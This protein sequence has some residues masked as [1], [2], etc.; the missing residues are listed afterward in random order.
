MPR[1]RR[2]M[3]TLLRR[4]SRYPCLHRRLLRSLRGRAAPRVPSVL[5]SGAPRPAALGLAGAEPGGAGH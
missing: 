5:S 4:R 1:A 3:R 2:S